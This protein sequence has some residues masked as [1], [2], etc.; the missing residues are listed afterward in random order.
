MI[1]ESSAAQRVREDAERLGYRRT[2]FEWAFRGHDPI[3]NLTGIARGSGFF[4]SLSDPFVPAC[5]TE[6]LIEA[7]KMKAPDARGGHLR[8]GHFGAMLASC[9]LQAEMASRPGI[10]PTRSRKG[11][12]QTGP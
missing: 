10:V 6:A 5:R 4:V 7:V 2:D 9:T 8:S 12:E 1:W 11:M 3:D